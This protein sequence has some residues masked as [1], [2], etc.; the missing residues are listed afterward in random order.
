MLFFLSTGW[1]PPGYGLTVFQGSDT[2]VVLQQGRIQNGFFTDNNFFQWVRTQPDFSSDT[3]FSKDADRVAF[4]FFRFDRAA[5]IL[6]E[7]LIQSNNR[8][9]FYEVVYSMNHW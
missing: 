2:F 1:I 4:H 7:L 8:S 9:E 6:F 3:V 5:G